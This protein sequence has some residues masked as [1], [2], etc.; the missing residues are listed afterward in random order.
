MRYATCHPGRTLLAK[1]L[2]T[3]CYAREYRRDRP[4]DPSASK[5]RRYNIISSYDGGQTPERVPGVRQHA[6][7]AFPL[8]ECPHCH[9]STT[10]RYSGREAHCVGTL[11]GCGATVYLVAESAE[12]LA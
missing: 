8:V 6:A 1:G 9:R 3:A 5:F 12:S 11:A 2:C 7:T 4:K 10:L